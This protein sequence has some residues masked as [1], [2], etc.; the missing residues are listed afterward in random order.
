LQFRP[1]PDEAEASIMEALRATDATSGAPEERKAA[2]VD[3][4]CNHYAGSPVR[5]NVT[6]GNVETMRFTPVPVVFEEPPPRPDDVS[7]ESDDEEE[8]KVVDA[9]ALVAAEAKSNVLKR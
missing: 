8:R 2:F 7:S 3:W 4:F 1:G 6:D 9:T 5:T